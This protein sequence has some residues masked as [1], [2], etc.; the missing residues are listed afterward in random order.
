MKLVVCKGVEGRQIERGSE[1]GKSKKRRVDVQ[2]QERVKDLHYNVGML[3]LGGVYPGYTDVSL[4]A[5]SFPSPLPPS[6]P[7]ILASPSSPCALP[8]VVH[9]LIH[10]WF[11]EDIIRAYAIRN[12]LHIYKFGLH[13]QWCQRPWWASRLRSQVTFFIYFIIHFSLSPYL[14][15]PPLPFLLSPLP[16]PPPPLHLSL[17]PL[18]LPLLSPPPSPSPLPLPLA[19][20]FE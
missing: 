13:S 8:Q 19:C 4:Q 18:P 20:E 3:V 10:L 17:S 11:G 5:L 1:G 9:L 14:P 16:S 2:H 15:P 12:V 7:P 6:L